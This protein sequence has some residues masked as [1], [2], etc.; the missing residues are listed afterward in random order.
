MGLWRSLWYD[1]EQR[2]PQL[3]EKYQRARKWLND[4]PKIIIGIAAV[5]AFILLVT[6]I[7]LFMPEKP[8]K[9]P[10]YKKAWFYDL[11]TKKLFVARSNKI[12]PIDAPSG[13]LPNDQPAG[14]KAYVFSYVYHPNEAERFIGFLET[15]DPNAEQTT[16]DSP[17]PET[18]ARQWGHGKLICR[19]DDPQW[20]PGNSPQARIIL[21]EVLRP[22]ENGER[23]QYCPPK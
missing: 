19:P 7:A 18:F 10:E 3:A 23:P 6:A 14:V 2:W 21:R 11:N 9:L 17:T 22:N 4:H 16:P 15:T 12:P 20:V 13:P 1:I 8:P 5:S